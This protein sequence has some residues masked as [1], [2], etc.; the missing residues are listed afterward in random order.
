M[1]C[2][3]INKILGFFIFLY[4]TILTIVNII[5]IFTDLKED[6]KN[7]PFLIL[8]TIIYGIIVIISI[9]FSMSIFSK[10]RVQKYL[11]FIQISGLITLLYHSI[12]GIILYIIHNKTNLFYIYYFLI[13][14]IISVISIILLFALNFNH[15]IQFIN[16]NYGGGEDI[17]RDQVI[18]NE[19]R[20]VYGEP[21][22]NEIDL[23]FGEV[24]KKGEISLAKYDS[25][26]E[27][28]YNNTYDNVYDNAY[29]N[30]YDNN[31]ISAPPEGI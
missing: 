26:Y 27:Y 12:S 29:D 14:C 5:H 22:I 21:S 25:E 7:N 4:N 19:D 1:N 13:L 17:N 3:F 24:E 2:F 10:N 31:F 9:Y 15:Q 23:E 11:G 28:E 16:Y 8:L 18:E 6:I 20:V 30:A